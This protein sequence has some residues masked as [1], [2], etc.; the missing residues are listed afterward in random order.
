ML[1]VVAEVALGH[2]EVVVVTPFGGEVLGDEVEPGL[3]KVVVF[4]VDEG[5]VEPFD[6]GGIGLS[7]KAEGFAEF[8]AG[9]I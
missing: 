7:E 1:E 9:D 2:M 6:E 4:S 5:A 3:E 8:P